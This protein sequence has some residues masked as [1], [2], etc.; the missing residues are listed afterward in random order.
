MAQR[1]ISRRAESK[2]VT[3]WDGLQGGRF[4]VMCEG[5]YQRVIEVGWGGGKILRRKGIETGW[6]EEMKSKCHQQLWKAVM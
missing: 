6:Y 3:A 1:H 4:H 5:R 2:V